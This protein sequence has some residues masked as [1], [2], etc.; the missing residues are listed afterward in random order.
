LLLRR[1][2]TVLA[3][4]D[5]D[6][7]PL[8]ATAARLR[9]AG[10]TVRLGSKVVFEGHF[11]FAVVSPGVASDNA[12]VREMKQRGVP[13]ISELELGYQHALC[14][15]IAI[16]GTNGKTTT[17]E[18]VERVLQHNQTKTI[19]AGNIGLPVSE[20][21]E[22]TR[23]L[24]VLIIEASSYQLEHTEYFRPAVAVLLNIT[25]DHLDRYASMEDY[26]RAKARI[27][28]NQQP[29]DFAIIQSEAL[30]QLRALNI[31]I[32]SKIVTFSATDRDA[33]IYFDR[34]LLVSRMA[35]WSG[36]LVDIDKCRIKGPHNAENL[37]AALAVGRAFRVPLERMVSAL[38]GY[39][40]APHRCELVAEINGV[41][42]I[43]DSK[44][45]NVD[46]LHKALLAVPRR[47]DGQPNVWLIAGG[48]DKGLE[49]HE[50]GPVLAQRVKGAF[51]IGETRAKIRA[52]WG[53]FIP[54][55]LTDSL[56]EAVTEAARSA[57][58]GDVVLLS[59]ACSSFDQFQNYQERG[60]VFR[61][62]VID[63][64]STL[65]R[66][67]AAANESRPQTQNLKPALAFL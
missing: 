22:Q 50:L 56:L 9:R 15:N 3:V 30:K 45:T 6:T 32:P 20:V 12:A 26:I 4:D 64:Q 21:A 43:N 60:D 24:D 37:M 62:A 42:F 17:T 5:F 39:E 34:G 10:A 31:E 54:C 51:L 2:A 65:A 46:A 23:E 11:H 13:V 48:K 59:P 16:T 33:D 8:K 63:L 27:F 52:A 1:G 57:V 67:R 40:P 53:L 44:A 38:A 61:R 49:Y 41:T 7:A 18:L 35:D 14:L 25:P 19:A 29:F 36:P 58:P 47:A 28:M 55:G 66:D